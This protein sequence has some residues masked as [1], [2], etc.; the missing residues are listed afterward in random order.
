MR[1]SKKRGQGRR[2]SGASTDEAAPKASDSRGVKQRET[3]PKGSGT[4]DAR[5]KGGKRR[6]RVLKEA[7]PKTGLKARPRGVKQRET[8]PKGSG[9]LDARMKGGRRRPRV[10]KETGPKT[11]LKVTPR[12]RKA[13]ETGPKGSETLRATVKGRRALPAVTE[14][15]A[16]GTLSLPVTEPKGGATLG[17]ATGVTEPKFGNSRGVLSHG[18]GAGVPAIL[19]L[20]PVLDARILGDRGR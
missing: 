17:T 3:G 6:P 11:G 4:L 18:R 10:L 12:G 13:R 19:G 7:G 9:T 8:G 15:K 2:T 5:V 20:P 14:P 16:D 1:P